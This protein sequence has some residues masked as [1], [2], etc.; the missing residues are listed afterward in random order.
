M[1]PKPL[2]TDA[3]KVD[4]RDERDNVRVAYPDIIKVEVK[5]QREATWGVP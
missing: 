1:L 2:F 3:P 4:D 5:V